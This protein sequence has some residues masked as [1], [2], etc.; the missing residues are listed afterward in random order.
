MDSRS[1]FV[2]F[3][4]K[5]STLAELQAGNQVFAQDEVQPFLAALR[6]FS[7]DEERD[8]ALRDLVPLLPEVDSFHAGMLALLCGILV[9]NGGNHTLPLN[10]IMELLV[11]QL[12]QL[13]DYLHT[14]EKLGP[15][16]QFQRFPE[17]SRA[18]ASLPFI[19]PAV[20]ALLCRDKEARKAWQRRQDIIDLVSELEDANLVPF[21]LKRTLTLLDDREL[22]VVDQHDKRAFLVR[23]VGVQDIMAH[24][25]ALLQ[26]ALLAYAVPDYADV[27]PTNPL[28]VRFAQNNNLT[29]QDHIDA[30]DVIEKLR[31]VF[32][33]PGEL[34][35][36]TT[37]SFSALPALGGLSF[38]LMAKQGIVSAPQAIWNP[39]N[40]YP[41]LHE[42]LKAS[43]EIVRELRGEEAELW[44]ALNSLTRE[45]S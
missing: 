6:Q 19:L 21:F 43:V 14:G 35:V 15:E 28:A 45:T 8:A 38:V 12:R 30:Q 7:S 17:A 18:R 16:D 20:M 37:A 9:E 1:P 42:E 11:R 25:F 13:Q 36:P 31:F 41:V 27:E 3:L 22:L 4:R 32:Y 33:Y 34:W 2:A 29:Q 23:L 26:H 39:A 44:T 24:C 5:P 10:A 40:L